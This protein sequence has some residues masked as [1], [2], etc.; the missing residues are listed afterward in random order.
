MNWTVQL[1]SG[2]KVNVLSD[3]E[4]RWFNATR[5]D[6][7][8]QTKFTE[9]TDLRDLD[10]LLVHELMIFR[11]TQWLARGGDYDG[12]EVDE[13]V[14]RRSM[15]EYSE[16][17]TKIKES[18]GLNK[19]ARDLASSEGDLSSRWANL[20]RRAKEFGVHREEQLKTALVLMNELS[21][22]VGT[23]DRSDQEERLKVGFTD[24]A[25]IV[26]WIRTIMLP[27]FRKVD[28]H[29]RKNQQRFWVREL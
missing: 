3:S 2:E 29:F 11:W 10:R 1:V 8:S 5:D 4:V 16:Q 21:T 26:D 9:T 7:L 12:L 19:K 18:M 28:E 23:F 6:Y 15:R 22:V 13:H 20:T 25:E 24:E 27:E 17:I 14:I